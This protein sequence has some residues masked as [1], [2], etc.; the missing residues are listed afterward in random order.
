MKAT[1]AGGCVAS[2]PLF[3]RGE[4]PGAI[5]AYS[6]GPASDNLLLAL[7]LL[8]A[9][10]SLSETDRSLRTSTGFAVAQ[11]CEAM[12]TSPDLQQMMC[13]VAEV[14]SVAI[15]ASAVYASSWNGSRCGDP[16]STDNTLADEADSR[17]EIEAALSETVIWQRPVIWSGSSD[18]AHANPVLRELAAAQNAEV[19]IGAPLKNEAG[20][21]VAAVVLTGD[22]TLAAGI[23]QPAVATTLKFAGRLVAAFNKQRMNTVSRLVH[24][25]KQFARTR[26]AWLTGAVAAAAVMLFCAPAPDDVRCNVTVQPTVRRF[27]VAPY[28]ALLKK[29]LVKPGDF[30]ERGQLLAQLDQREFRLELAQLQAEH[31]RFSKKCDAE[32]AAGQIAAGQLAS[33]EVQRVRLRQEQLE[34]RLQ[35]SQVVSPVD[36][37]IVSGDLHR[38]EGAQ[39][40]RGQTLFEVAPLE[41]MYAEIEVPDRDI[42]RIGG[43][44][45]VSIY[46][47]T[48]A[49]SAYAGKIRRV[50]PKSETRD[51]EN[52][53]IAETPLD[54]VD[55]SLRPGMKGAARIH[56]GYAMLGWI[57]LR[58]PWTSL[59]AIAGW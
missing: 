37:V 6:P 22:K 33:L 29:P 7:E 45:E 28:D 1:S 13:K 26:P 14:I 53:F 18:H 59:R 31:E 27:V 3:R 48:V 38:A 49:S 32:I 8:S 43:L 39:L 10:L 51:G 36:G 46:L 4:A 25:A 19:A 20:E 56:T 12:L 50:R 52:I 24:D 47:D 2:V 58:Q 16:V 23:E 17:A 57:W 41:K 21:V 42:Q 54:N 35:Q 30:V 55:K 15:G 40:T 11:L 5:V 44:E 34:H 9:H